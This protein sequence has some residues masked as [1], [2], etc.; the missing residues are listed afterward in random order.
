MALLPSVS[1]SP[2]AP[3]GRGIRSPQALLVGLA[4]VAAIMFGLARESYPVLAYVMGS[5]VTLE[6]LVVILRYAVKGPEADR[7]Q[8]TVTIVQ[9]AG[10][11][12]L[13]LRNIDTAEM[14]ALVR[15]AVKFRKPLPPPA[16]IV[17]GSAADPT[18]IEEV[19]PE[20][21]AALLQEDLGED[22]GSLS[23][24]TSQPKLPS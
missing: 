20:R 15:L 17:R 21:A 9:S 23:Q 11:Q 19:S 14:E 18:A 5:V 12:T 16:G 24:T 8:P 1:E 13:E 2:L 10:Q 7:M 22:V 3:F 6:L 4:G